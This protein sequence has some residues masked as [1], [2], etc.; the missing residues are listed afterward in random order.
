MLPKL[1]LNVVVSLASGLVIR[2][3]KEIAK[4]SDNTLDDKIIGL[5]E[6]PLKK[7]LKELKKK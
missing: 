7:A 2:G 5:I 6:E 1:A 4:R 3:L